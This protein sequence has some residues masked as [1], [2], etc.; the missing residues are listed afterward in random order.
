VKWA[1]LSSLRRL[2]VRIGRLRFMVMANTK[3]CNVKAL[4][5]GGLAKWN[6]PRKFEGET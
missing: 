4:G 1:L 6:E 3:L 2:A 5:H